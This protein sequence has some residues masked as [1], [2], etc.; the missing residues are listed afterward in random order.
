MRLH[1]G[2]LR[3]RQKPCLKHFCKH[4]SLHWLPCQTTAQTLEVLGAGKATCMNELP[5]SM[6]EQCT[7]CSCLLPTRTSI[8]TPGGQPRDDCRLFSG[9]VH[10]CPTAQCFQRHSSSSR[11][12]LPGTHWHIDDMSSKSV[13]ICRVQD[14]E[15]DGNCCNQQYLPVVAAKPL[16][17][18]L[19]VIAILTNGQDPQ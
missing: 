4:C 3:G 15:F 5:L 16:C 2:L 13:D 1:E 11:C 18:S 9:A 6:R 14:H 19:V 7:I 12:M 17:R 8:K 10:A